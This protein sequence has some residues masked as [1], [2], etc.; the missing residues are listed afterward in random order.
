ME[1]SETVAIYH[2]SIK[3]I[4]RGK[5]KSAV[6]AAAYRA[7]QTITNEYDGITH[8]YTRKRGVV[9][10]EI[11]LPQNAPTRYLDRAILWNAVEWIEKAKNSQLA[12]EIQIAL[13]KELS[14]MQNKELVRDYVKQHFVAQGMC[15]DIA[16]HDTGSGNPHAHIMLTMRPFEQ[17]GEWG[18][19][20]KKVYHLDKDGNKI[21]DPIKRQYKCNK[22][23]TT[24][25]NE[26]TKA[27]E[28]R[29]AWAD[30][31][32]A[33]LERRN[34]AERIDH[35]S[36][37]RQGK[38]EIPTVHLG[39]AAFQMEKRGI[40]TER[41]NLNR[42]IEVTNARLRQLKARIA[43]LETWLKEEAVNAE[44]PSLADVI[45]NIF[46]QWA[47]AGKSDRY[48]SVA[49]L[50]TASKMFNFLQENEIKDMAGLEEKVKCMYE[51]QF[52]LRDKLKPVERRLKTLDAHI[53]QA[54]MYMQHKAVYRQYQEQK[55]KKQAAFAE[56][57]HAEI[58]LFESAE[59]YLKGVMNGKITLPIKVWRAERDALNADK[60]KLYQKYTSLKDEVHEVEQIRRSVSAIMRV[61]TPN[62]QPTRTQTRLL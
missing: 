15:A 49:N 23:Q 4:S 2:C 54:T 27:E 20:Q 29:A 22:I 33:H 39:P 45:S 53:Q 7:G 43:K 34:L 10:T 42:E 14:L 38:E 58:S 28:W 59:R 51:K 60:T 26:Q 61:Q 3:I 25:W 35:R 18:D 62:A 41:G 9:H 31:V 5:G 32:N 55:P 52:D 24:D 13:P 40:A 16:I 11:L 12:R 30:H 21:Y 46:S 6:A 56:K 8:D 17:N 57:H 44:L 19:K 37:V 50:K 47:Q 48:Q 36:F 1:R